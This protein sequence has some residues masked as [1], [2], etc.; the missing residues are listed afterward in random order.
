[1]TEVNPNPHKPNYQFLPQRC[2]TALFE[3]PVTAAGA[4]KAL[5][6]AQFPESDIQL[7]AG[8][9]GAKQLD[10]DAEKQSTAT[11]LLQ[12]VTK[13]LADDGSY[14]ERVAGKLRQGYALVSVAVDN[15]QRAA[16]QASNILKEQG[17]TDVQH[18][19]DWTTEKL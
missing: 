16:E 19:G 2:V 1:M 13:A 12:A 3:S 18:W 5:R 17:G 9:E 4:V 6:D 14:L 7:F 10:V 11:K 15:D 8:K